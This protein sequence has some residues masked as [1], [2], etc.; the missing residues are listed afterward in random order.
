MTQ[1]TVLTAS[2]AKELQDQVSGNFARPWGLSRVQQY[3]EAGV[4]NTLNQGEIN[5]SAWFNGTDEML[6]Q[7]SLFGA[8]E[9]S[10]RFILSFWVKRTEISAAGTSPIICTD[11]SGNEEIIRFDADD[12]LRVNLNNNAHVSD[13]VFRDTGWYHFVV[14]VEQGG[15]PDLSVY[16]N[17]LEI[18]WGTDVA[19]TANPSWFNTV[20]KIRIGKD[21][22]SAFGAIYISQVLGLPQVSIQN[23]DHAVTDFGIFR[24]VGSGR[25]EWTP[26]SDEE[27]TALATSLGGNAFCLTDGIGDGT[28]ASGNGNGFTPTIMDHATNGTDDTPSNQKTVLNILTNDGTISD[29]ALRWR[30]SRQG[31]AQASI[32]APPNSGSYYAEVTM[33]TNV[34]GAM[35]G[36]VGEGFYY[37]STITR[38][39]GDAATGLVSIGYSLNGKKYINGTGTTY[40][41]S[42][43]TL[44][45]IGIK[46][47]TDNGEV[48][49]WKNGSSQGP[50]S[51]D[52]TVAVTFASG[53]A[54]G[55]GSSI[56]DWD[57]GATAP[58]NEKILKIS[59]I[60]KAAYLAND[61]FQASTYEGNGSTKSI[62]GLG[63]QPD[64]IWIKNRTTADSHV[65]TDSIRG[66]GEIISIDT[67]IAEATDADTITSFDSDGFSL[68]ADVKVN[69]NLE[70]YVSWNW[71]AGGGTGVTNSSGSIT[72][73]VSVA[74]PGHFSIISYTGNGTGGA[75][76]G[77]G[78][79]GVPQFMMFK[80]LSDVE[81]WT[82]Q[83]TLIYGGTNY[84]TPTT[85]AI[86]NVSSQLFNDID[87]DASVITLGTHNRSNGSPD[88]IICYAFRSVDGVCKV[89]S[90]TGNGLVD[91]AYA[92]TGFKS[93]FVLIKRLDVIGSWFMYDT[94]RS[95]FNEM[96][97]QLL[98]EINTAET[99]G[100]EEID[101][102]FN[103]FKIRTADDQINRNGGDY[104]FLAM[105]DIAL[106]TESDVTVSQNNH[107]DLPILSRVSALA[108]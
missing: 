16:V 103:G 29:G 4:W 9:E 17:G 56:Q 68:G 61:Y 57:F 95:T 49:F 11:V 86:T 108:K 73:T 53:Y 78:L 33:T 98:A 65:L 34:S 50:I 28:D 42:Y 79:Q 60:P 39:P 69:T 101:F 82:A 100:S 66:A 19:I 12:K 13:Q 51:F 43:G 24:T 76:I 32:F 10:V 47:D 3:Q 97:D 18:T 14:S 31:C 1:K 21:S 107:N 90:Y 106:K 40:G 92:H 74:E 5:Q 26:R 105:A 63:F 102:L 91:G 94:S 20:N 70:D 37:R 45:L 80:N 62:T 7:T 8:D 35:V 67:T 2:Q 38:Y 59:S 23:S 75:T 104:I 83:E 6:E 71:L 54:D 30:S 27:I 46:I 89:G 22:A 52:N 48:T 96:D 81:D 99:T 84:L 88:P 64:L 25:Q 58:S 85:S 72:S 93:R 87:A 41:E 15:S 44:T 36:I 55:S 77:H